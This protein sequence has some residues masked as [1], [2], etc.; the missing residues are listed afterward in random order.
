MATDMYK[1][2][3][4][5][6][7]IRPD[8]DTID[9][10][11]ESKFLRWLD[12]YWYHYKWHTIIVAFVLILTLIIIFQQ[13]RNPAKDT[14]VTYCGPMGFLS[15]ETEELREALNRIMPEDFDGNGEKYTEIVRYQVYSEQELQ[16]D[17]EA[18]DGMGTVNLSYNTKQLSDFNNFM[19]FGEC[20]V[21]ILSEYMYEYLKANKGGLLKPLADVLGELPENAYDEYA[22]RLKDTAYYAMEPALQQLPEDTLICITAPYLVGSSADPNTYNNSLAMFRAIVTGK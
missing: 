5:N 14:L 20:S 10:I 9:I 7:E 17:K 12:N 21:Y 13:I 1:P 8:G 22:V 18:N 2:D 19:S 11:S 3:G 15:E 6:I 4:N 16:A